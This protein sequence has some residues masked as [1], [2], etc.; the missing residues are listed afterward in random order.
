MKLRNVRMSGFLETRNSF[1]QIV[2][3]GRL[4]RNE[5]RAPICPSE[6]ASRTNSVGRTLALTLLLN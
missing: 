2:D 3:N 6:L 1:R 4:L 5:F